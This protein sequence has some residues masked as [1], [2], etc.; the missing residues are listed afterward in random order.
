ML[1]WTIPSTFSRK[2]K[3]EPLIWIAAVLV[4]ELSQKY[5]GEYRVLDKRT[6]EMIPSQELLQTGWGTA[7]P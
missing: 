6:G 5:P 1:R 3:T 7:E 4:A 2:K